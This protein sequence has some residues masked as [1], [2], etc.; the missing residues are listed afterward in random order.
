MNKRLLLL[1]MLGVLFVVS[2]TNNANQFLYDASDTLSD[3]YI[4]DTEEE[5][6]EDDQDSV[7]R[8]FS[9]IKC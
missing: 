1:L 5:E 3:S 9:Y 4:E 7:S 2:C 6:A 8:H